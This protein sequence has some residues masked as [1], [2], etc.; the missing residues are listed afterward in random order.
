MRTHVIAIFWWSIK[1][2]IVE[3]AI[4]YMLPTVSIYQKIKNSLIFQ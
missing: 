1:A 2:D 4:G 3:L